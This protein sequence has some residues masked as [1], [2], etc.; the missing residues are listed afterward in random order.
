MPGVFGVSL[1]VLQGLGSYGG[2]CG[3]APQRIA[4]RGP[5]FG[6]AGDR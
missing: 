3:R 1:E 5:L 6:G 2:T 4:L